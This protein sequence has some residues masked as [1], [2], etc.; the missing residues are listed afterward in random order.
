MNSM[1]GFGTGQ[2]NEKAV[3]VCCE[4]RSVNHKTIDVKVRVPR[5]CASSEISVIDTIKKT[6]ARGRV[7]ATITVSGPGE[8]LKRLSLD[9][10]MLAALLSEFQ[11]LETSFP[12]INSQVNI[13]DLLQIPGLV[14][15]ETETV[16]PDKLKECVT[17]AVN[18]ALHDLKK[19]RA[20][21]G[22][23]LGRI[24]E[25]QIDRCEE[26]LHEVSLK[27]VKKPEDLKARLQEKYLLLDSSIK[28][29]PNR[30]A[31]EVLILI[32]RIDVTEELDRLRIHLQHFRDFLE[33]DE[34]V[35]RKMDFLCQ[36]LFREV[37]TLGNKVSDAEVAYLVVEFKSELQR[38]REQVQNI[39]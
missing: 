7:D 17:E 26:L 33:K 19:S 8:A 23:S 35:G 9:H 37:N 34:T 28:V 29:D 12:Q 15:Q 30:L 4:I 25:S 21:E 10:D 13:G 1:T 27:S 31:Q 24:F 2:I 5:D 20:S 36:E 22:E 6:V 18:L 32:E 39:E 3:C 38:I 16:A 14:I 11:K